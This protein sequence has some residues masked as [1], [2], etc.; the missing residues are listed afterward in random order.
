MDSSR[1][2]VLAI[3]GS[4]RKGGD[5]AILLR[6]VLK[7]LEIEGIE[8][9][10]VERGGM[11]SHGCLSCRKCAARRDGLCAQSSDMGNVLIEKITAADGFVFGSPTY[12]CG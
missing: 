7:E 4:A 3:N 11:N 6:Y 2:K 1:I 5:T 8:T 10:L 12:H 9:E